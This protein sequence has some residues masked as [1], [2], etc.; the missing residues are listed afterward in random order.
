[1]HNMTRILLIMAAVFAALHTTAFA[2]KPLK[3]FIIAGDENVVGQGIISRQE[4]DGREATGTL[5]DV[6]S[7]QPR[8]A[9][10]KGDDGKWITR[11]DVIVYDGHPLH[12][13][14]VSGGAPLQVSPSDCYGGKN[15]HEGFGPELMFGHLLGD[16]LEERILVIRFGLVSSSYAPVFVRLPTIISR[17]R[18]GPR[19]R[20]REIGISST[21][22][23]GCGIRPDESMG[24]IRR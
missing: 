24:L 3:V 17:P 8:F 16:A 19:A 23:S 11:D 1:M 9:F 4:E 15:I 14:T 2:A 10:L 20:V 21:S 6:I 13:N 12:N 18:P 22:I 5:A 7:K